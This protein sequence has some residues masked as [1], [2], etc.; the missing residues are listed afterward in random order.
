[1]YRIL[2]VEEAPTLGGST[3]CL[4]ELVRKID[5][6]RYDPFVLFAYDLAAREMFT[7]K[8]IQNVTEAEIKGAPE[9]VSPGDEKL[10]VPGYKR[11]GPYRLLGSLKRYA[12][13]QRPRA[14][15]LARWIAREG[16]A[17]VHTN[18]S[19]TANLAALVAASRAGVPAVSHQRGYF[20]P[21]A[22]ERFAAR[23]VDRF[24]C[25]SHSIADHYVAQGLPRDRIMTVH[26]GIDVESLRPRSRQAQ[27]R[28]LI[29]WAGRLISW[30]GASV[31]VEAAE[32]ILE[33]RQ[34]VD[35]VIAGTGP[36]LPGLREK[37]ARRALLRDHVRIP[38]FSRDVQD[39][40]ARSDIFVN[41]S[42]EPEPLGHSA[43]EALAFG[44]PVVASACGGLPEVVEHGRNG[45]L[46]EP[47]STAA[48]VGELMKLIDDGN[49][50]ARFGI[51]GRRR[52]ERIFSLEHHVR[53]IEAVYEAVL[54]RA[55]MRPVREAT[56][57]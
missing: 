42:I 12:L 22:L 5:R 15:W 53:T 24:I 37:I 10:V 8:R 41:T 55:Q 7:S 36:E 6:S 20:R 50:R 47:G 9:P 28:I 40:I 30:K 29:A 17:L 46:F 44:V 18:N 21:T 31:L 51:E 52:A 1:L 39:L 56:K 33:R 43:L 23:T 54:E 16:F 32:T 38:G 2:Y 14:A 57:P 26:D 27:G 13:I 48:L 25:I 4:D 3:V 19:V 34:D 45:F 35:F 11:T 49:L